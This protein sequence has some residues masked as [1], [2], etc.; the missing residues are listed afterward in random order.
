[1]VEG[2]GKARRPVLTTALL[3]IGVFVQMLCEAWH[4]V[5]LLSFLPESYNNS[6]PFVLYRGA[7]GLAIVNFILLMTWLVKATR[8]IAPKATPALTFTPAWAVVWWFIPIANFITP[9][10][11]MLELY[12]A[13][14]TQ[15]AWSHRHWPV[16]AVLWWGATLAGLGLVVVERFGD[17]MGIDVPPIEDMNAAIYGAGALRLLCLLILV[18]MIARF[19]KAAS[20]SNPKIENVF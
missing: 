6:I 17:A 14:R 2:S 9:F 13:S 16:L 10:M 15:T 11:V 7:L 3:Q 8:F 20:T 18:T 5:D 19:Q 4:A 12:N 1:M